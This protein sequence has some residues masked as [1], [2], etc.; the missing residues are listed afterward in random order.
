MHN[1]FACDI[2]ITERKVGQREFYSIEE[3]YDIIKWLTTQNQITQ[4]VLCICWV[5]SGQ[6][7]TFQLQ[8]K[9]STAWAKQSPL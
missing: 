7:Q 6:D 1:D 5:N 4:A 8:G 3:V 2:I 9:Q